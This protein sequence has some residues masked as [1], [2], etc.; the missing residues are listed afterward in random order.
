MLINL[1]NSVDVSNKLFT[2]TDS[3]LSQ[4]LV[5]KNNLEES[6]A[7]EIDE[8][9]SLYYEKNKGKQVIIKAFSFQPNLNGYEIIVN[10]KKE[11]LKKGLEKINSLNEIK[12]VVNKKD[13]RLFEKLKVH[14]DVIKVPAMTD[15]YDNKLISKVYGETNNVIIYDI[16]DVIKLGQALLGKEIESYVTV[17]G[18][19]VEGNKVI[20]INSD[21]T[22]NDVFKALNGKEDILTKVIDGGSLN[23]TPVYDINSKINKD[24]K[25]LLF[26]SNADLPSSEKYSCINCAKCLRVCPE[27]L[28]PV[29]LMELSKRNEKEEFIKFGGD[30]C[31]DCGLCS[32]VCP[33]N[34]EVAQII[35]T[36]KVFN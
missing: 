30:K 2:L 32:F 29:K 15:L 18:S 4:T 12:F 3:K 11:E 25:G 13:K 21:T 28:S 10:E 8:S 31:I 19:A 9:L 26:L 35:K 5:E 17:Y 27:G 33:S 6:T 34:I 22:Y 16:L 24:S 1:F 14:G 20:V 36:S 7:R 23:G